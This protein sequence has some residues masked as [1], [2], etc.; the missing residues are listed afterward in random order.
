MVECRK[1]VVQVPEV[2]TV[3]VDKAVYVLSLS[4]DAANALLA[5]SKHIGGCPDRSG[6]KHWSEIRN[7]L[8]KHDG[9]SDYNK[10]DV[11]VNGYGI[12]YKS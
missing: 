2:K 9:L 5:V 7:A 1:E 10:F 12:Y 11:E 4:E 6:R 8:L 3:M